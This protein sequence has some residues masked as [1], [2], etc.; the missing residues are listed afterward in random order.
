MPLAL[1]F[2][3][4]RAK[5]EIARRARQEGVRQAAHARRARPPSARRS[6]RSAGTSRACVTRRRWAPCLRPPHPLPAAAGDG[7]GAGAVRRR[8]PADR[9]AVAAALPRHRR[10]AGRG[11]ARPRR[12]ALH[13]A[14]LRPPAGDGGVPQRLVRRLRR[15][16][17]RRRL[18][19]RDVLPRAGRRGVRRA[20]GST[21]GARGLEGARAGRRRSTS[22]TRCSTRC[23][24][25]SPT[26]GTPVVVH[27]G[28][29]PVATAFTG[30]APVAGAAGPAPA[31]AAGDR[32]RRAR[33]STPSSSSWPSATSGWRSTPRWRSPT[34]STRWARRTRRRCCRGCATS[35]WPGKVL[36][37]TRLPEH[38]VP[39]RAPAGGAAASRPRRRLAACGALGQRGPPPR[40]VSPTVGSQPPG[41]TDPPHNPRARGRGRGN[42]EDAL[43]VGPVDCESST[44][45]NSRGA[46][47]FRLGTLVPGEAGRE[48]SVIS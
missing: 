34:S 38:P 1:Y 48:A 13:R 30:P 29:G 35:G 8:R 2:K 47:R 44:F 28:S 46:D 5:V 43:A 19:V 12:T 33:R 15:P 27:A 3:D 7:E 24:A 16:G 41:D 10:G 31:A 26:P 32:P 39:V 22:A 21:G 37:G 36:L 9:P 11:A 23:G 6:R 42:E 40:R 17:A 4:G 20:T 45:E 18:R 14:R 25:C